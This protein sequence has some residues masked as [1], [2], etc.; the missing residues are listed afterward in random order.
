MGY[1]KLVFLLDPGPQIVSLGS[2]QIYRG[3]FWKRESDKRQSGRKILVGE[4]LGGG[5]SNIF[6]VHPDPWGNDPI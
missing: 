2:Q 1:N 6:Y 5:N 4:L 3:D